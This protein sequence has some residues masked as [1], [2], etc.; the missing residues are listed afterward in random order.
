MKKVEQ[1]ESKRMRAAQAAKRWLKTFQEVRESKMYYEKIRDF[2]PHIEVQHES[3]DFL[4]TTAQSAEELLKIL[5][6]RH[7]IFVWE[8]QG[9]KAFHGLD[10]D[11]YDFE[12]DHLMIIDKKIDKVVGT[13]RLL[14]SK[15]ATKFYSDSEFVLDEFLK[16]PEVKLEMGRACVHQDY[17]DGNTI[18]LLWKGLSAYIRAAKVNYL[19]GCSSVKTTDAE[20]MSA[21]F[22]Y[23]EGRE[24]WSDDHHIRT[25][26]K[27]DFTGFDMSKAQ[28]LPVL[29]AKEMIPPLL[30]SYVNAGA[31]V[32][33]HP[34]L[35]RD[36]AC[37]DLLTILDLSRL[38]TKFQARYLEGFEVGKGTPAP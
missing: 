21:L 25:R 18:D 4:V 3:E 32:Y 20:K 38:N 35:D 34:A 31:K 8:W 37:A 19:F 14:C 28:A 33:G 11:D 17:R 13:Y 12:G 24:M 23:F 27:Y 22:K 30:R 5:E 6:L 26:K 10:V 29:E 16:G 2:Q 15:F 9:R 36:F 1:K 7:E